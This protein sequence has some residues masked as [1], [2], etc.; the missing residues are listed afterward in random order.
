MSS[1]YHFYSS[2][3]HSG[4][5]QISDRPEKESHQFH[6]GKVFAPNLLQS[7]NWPLLPFFPR[8]TFL[9]LPQLRVLKKNIVRL[10]AGHEKTRE[11]FAKS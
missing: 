2:H 1:K 8:E 9:K 10:N 5:G 7:G 11:A 6:A 3:D 4:N